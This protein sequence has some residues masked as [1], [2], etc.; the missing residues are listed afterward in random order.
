M[1]ELIITD[2]S[3]ETLKK[4]E[5][6]RRYYQEHREQIRVRNNAWWQAHKEQ[7][8]I[9]DQEY[10]ERIKAEVLEYYGGGKLAC[11]H[12][13]FSDIRALSIDHIDGRGKQHRQNLGISRSLT[14]YRWLQGQDY[15][16]GYQTL[17]MNCQF[18][19]RAENNEQT[20]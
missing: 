14:F 13:G 1:E 9:Y 5:Y 16:K 11:A 8:R 15:P 12:C 17:C 3:A 2:N 4:R 10:R 20:K 7:R 6:D 19:K 18:V